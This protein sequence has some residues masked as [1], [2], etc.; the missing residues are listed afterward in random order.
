[1]AFSVD[2]L[3]SWSDNAVVY[4]SG[5]TLPVTVPISISVPISNGGLQELSAH[6]S[7]DYSRTSNGLTVAA[8]VKGNQK[9]NSADAVSVATV[10]GSGLI[11]IG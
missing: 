4:M 2:G 3:I 7:F 8:V 6:F 11:E 10:Y 5:Q 1:M 9:F